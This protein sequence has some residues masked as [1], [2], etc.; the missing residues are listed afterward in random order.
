MDIRSVLAG[1]EVRAD[2]LATDVLPAVLD[3]YPVKFYWFAAHGYVPHVYQAAFHGA[4]NPETN[5]L[6][7]F[8]HLVAGRRGGKTLSAAWE[9]LFYAL[10]PV[11]FHLDVHGVESDRPLWVWLLTKDYPTGFP[12]LQTLMDVMRQIGLVKGRDYQFNKTE[13][14]I[15]F[16]ASGS[17]I[18]FKTADD[19]QSLRGAGLDILWMDEAAFIPTDEAYLVTYPAITDRQGLVITTTTPHGKNWLF[20][21]FFE[22]EALKSADE[23]RVQYTSI[24]NPYFRREEWERAKARYHPIFFKQE[25]LASFDAFHGVAL[26]GDWLKYYVTG[27]PDVKTG[28]VTVKHLRTDDGRYHLRVFIGVDPAAS[29]SDR[30]DHFA[31][32]AVGVTDDNAQAFLL[33]TFVGRLPFPDQLDLIREWQLKWRPDLIG[34]ESNAYQTVLAQQAARLDTFPGV[35][36]TMAKGKKNDRILTMSPLFKIGKVRIHRRHSDFIDQWLSFDPEKKN[37]EDDLLDAVEI[38]LSTAGI[39]LPM[40]PHESLLD[41]V[42]PRVMTPH[43]NALAQIRSLRDG[44]NRPYDPELGEE[45]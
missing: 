17:V 42:I 30:A 28:D 5:R 2:Q 4:T 27:N 32:A 16:I 40:N 8:R 19:P 6:T 41:P 33:D 20:T 12:S 31:I 25:F 10:H 38:A 7:R 13:R 9:V 24:D 14:R 22:G 43:E 11:A 18:Q 34:V 15:E 35:I 26:Q 39:L 3:R 44:A 45:A 29:L 36:P 21:E 37:Q 1:G 23:F